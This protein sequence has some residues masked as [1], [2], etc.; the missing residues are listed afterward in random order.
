MSVPEEVME[1]LKVFDRQALHAMELVLVHPRTG[2]FMEFSCPL[3]HD[4][5]ALEAALSSALVQ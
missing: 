5:I 4:I 1:A 3:P 2:E